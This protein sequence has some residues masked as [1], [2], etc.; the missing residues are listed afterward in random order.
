VIARVRAALRLFGASVVGGL[1]AG[2]VAG[3]GARVAMWVI[4][5]MN[6]SHNGEVTHANAAVGR[7]TSS[8]TVEIVLTGALIFGLP[9]A[10]L[11][12]IV[13]R[14]LPGRPLVRG[15]LFGVV[16]L[17]LGAAAFV[18]DNEYE[19]T[20]YVSPAVSVPLFMAL[21]PIYGV[22]LAPVAEGLGRGSL[23]PPTHRVVRVGG[24]LALLALVGFGSLAFVDRIQQSFA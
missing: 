5:L 15:V 11:Y 17:A 2:A 3:F 10:V 13:R 4:R 22:V 24:R 6:D 19:Y 9:G 1:L 14:W 8:G 16:L 21:F 12:L 20:R 18:Q 7:W 23:A